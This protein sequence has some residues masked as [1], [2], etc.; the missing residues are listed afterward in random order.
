MVRRSM[1][2]ELPSTSPVNG[3]VG[4]ALAEAFRGMDGR[5]RHRA[6]I[7][8][9]LLEHLLMSHK[10]PTKQRK[11]ARHW[12]LDKVVGGGHIDKHPYFGLRRV[13]A[14]SYRSPATSCMHSVIQKVAVRS[15]PTI[16]RERK[17]RG[18]RSARSGV[19]DTFELVLTRTS[20]SSTRPY[21]SR[22]FASGGGD[23][24]AWCQA[25]RAEKTKYDNV[26]IAQ[27]KH[28][29]SGVHRTGTQPR[30]VRRRCRPLKLFLQRD[31][32]GIKSR[33]RSRR[34]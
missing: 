14:R 13:A 30:R 8:E 23:L 33:I 3:D 6:A 27:A 25:Y 4:F 29:L 26:T 11:T 21:S 24:S 5:P 16:T 12:A 19:L 7:V 20:Q 17:T 31:M 2:V 15:A 18:N 32:K 28:S 1:G 9:E 22:A 34:H 10:A